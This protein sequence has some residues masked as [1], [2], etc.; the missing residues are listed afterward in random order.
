VAVADARLTGGDVREASRDLLEVEREVLRSRRTETGPGQRAIADVA[1]IELPRLPDDVVGVTY[2]AIEGT[3]YGLRQEGTDVTLI[4][5]GAPE[6]VVANLRAQRTRLRRLADER[7]T[8]IETNLQALERINR[9]LDRMLLQPLDLP[10]GVPV[11]VAPTIRLRDVAWAAL[12]SMVDRPVTITSS[13]TRWANAPEQLVVGSATALEGV[14]VA[15][16]GPEV[17]AVAEL[18]PGARLLRNATCRQAIDS[19]AHRGLVHVAA[20]GTLRPDNA[21]FSAIEFVDGPLTLLDMVSLARLP[22]MMV[23]ASCDAAA[24]VDAGQDAA[25]S[26]VNELRNHGVDVVL[27]PLV[28]VNDQAAAEY[29]VRLHQLLAGGASIDRAA[30][31]ARQELLATG[32]PRRQATAM[33]FTVFGGRCTLQPLAHPSE[34]T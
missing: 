28:A 18:W 8:T 23:L 17:E 29:S 5:L 32:D 30:V 26:A 4:D 20:H 1:D 27:A 19:F 6:P 14:D 12:P 24:G 2:I 9:E 16:S 25:V 34:V 21:F 10:P 22:S 31:T 3:L 15:A 33:A 13:F 11:V 7:R